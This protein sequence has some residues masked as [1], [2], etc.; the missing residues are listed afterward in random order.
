MSLPGAFRLLLVLLSGLA[1]VSSFPRPL[2]LDG[3]TLAAW[4]QRRSNV[5]VTRTTRIRIHKHV[6]EGP[7][8]DQHGVEHAPDPISWWTAPEP[9]STF[10]DAL[11]ALTARG[12]QVRRVLIVSLVGGTCR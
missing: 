4:Q 3:K 5:T 1:P 12:R 6:R 8:E 2:V 7:E 10:D 11:T 9:R